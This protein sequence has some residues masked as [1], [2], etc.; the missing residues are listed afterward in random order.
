MPGS[1]GRYQVS[2]DGQVFGMRNKM[3]R[4]TTDNGGYESVWITYPDGKR[5]RLVHHL[6]LETFVGPRPPGAETRHLNGN[7]SDNRVSNLAWGTAWEN[8]NDKIA[9]GTKHWPKRRTECPQ[10]HPYDAENTAWRNGK[11]SCLEC[12]RQTERRR[13]IRAKDAPEAVN[14]PRARPLS[15]PQGHPYDEANTHVDPAGAWR[16]RKCGRDK[17]RARRAAARGV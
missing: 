14:R 15:C 2:D 5:M 6:V 10:G 12:Q 3:L 9:H 16:C 13:Y 11:Q 4:P 1:A 8:S 7:P 17:A